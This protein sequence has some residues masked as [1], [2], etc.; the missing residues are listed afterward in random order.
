MPSSVIFWEWVKCFE[1]QFLGYITTYSLFRCWC[2]H[3]NGLQSGP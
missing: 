3:G 2:K 1:K